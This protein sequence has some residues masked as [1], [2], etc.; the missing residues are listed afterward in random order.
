M[1][2]S[3]D[4]DDD[5]LTIKCA[6]KS[7]LEP[8]VAPT[9]L[10]VIEAAVEFVSQLAARG[11]RL[12]N[13]FLVHAAANDCLPNV[14]NKDDMERFVRQVMKL[15]VNQKPL[16]KPT[17]GLSEWYASN[18]NRYEDPP[19]AALVPIPIKEISDYCCKTYLTAFKN[20][21]WMNHESRL[22]KYLKARW[23]DSGKGVPETLLYMIL[24]YGNDYQRRADIA[25]TREQSEFIVQHRALFGFVDPMYK[26]YASFVEQ[27]WGLDSGEVNAVMSYFV[28]E[29]LI[30]SGVQ[31]V[32]TEDQSEFVSSPESFPLFVQWKTNAMYASFVKSFAKKRW[33]LR[34][35]EVQTVMSYLPDGVPSPEEGSPFCLTKEQA[36]FVSSPE[37]FPSFVEWESSHVPPW[38]LRDTTTWRNEGVYESVLRKN[39]DVLLMSSIE[40]LRYIEEHNALLPRD[41][42][43][44]IRTWTV[45]PLSSRKRHFV[46]VDG[47]ILMQML[48]AI[49]KLE[50]GMKYTQFQPLAVEQFQ[51]VFRVRRKGIKGGKRSHRRGN[52]EQLCMRTFVQTDGVVLNVQFHRRGVEQIKGGIK[53]MNKRKRDQEA[54]N[55]LQAEPSVPKQGSKAKRATDKRH[56]W[57]D[58]SETHD[59]TIVVAIDPGRANIIYAVRDSDGMEFR[60]TNGQYQHEGGIM[61][62]RDSWERWNA[63]LQNI[64]DSIGQHSPKT[65]SVDGWNEFLDVDT[66]AADA[67]WNVN[68]SKK[69]SRMRFHTHCNTKKVMES[70]V[71]KFGKGVRDAKRRILVGYGQAKFAPT[72]RGEMAVP[73]TQSFK[74][75]AK[76]WKTR[77]V[78]ENYTTAV[79]AD[80]QGRLLPVKTNITKV[81]RSGREY[82]KKNRGVHRCTSACKT[83]GHSLKNRDKN[84]CYNIG[85]ILIADVAGLPRPSRFTAA[86]APPIPHA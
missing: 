52:S 78:N 60:L 64:Y 45:A 82:T 81:N 80:C 4:G 6:L 63:P 71:A 13:G 66:A 67:I 73:T 27:F 50:K 11:S 76:M 33:S 51:S 30:P 77:L 16:N 15:G 39:C 21:L 49:D 31:F 2:P 75:V 72:G 26:V 14:K 29:D 41:S 58:R 79:C 38:D 56:K 9:I 23:G 43:A 32:L 8:D 12:A 53:A 44:T 57:V 62:S 86:G 70:F 34:V 74:T 65:A 84:A 59:D 42:N 7:S 83:R 48:K 36:E 24:R 54:A 85:A 18:S 35:G 46:T 47:E 10:P 68:Y 55:R 40:F 17:R 25:P 61:Y 28:R 3:S 22:L 19:N 37:S 5:I 69:A 1:E 20:N